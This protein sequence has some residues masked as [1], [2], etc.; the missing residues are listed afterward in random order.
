[1]TN[2]ALIAHSPERFYVASVPELN[3]V[4]GLALASKGFIFNPSYSRRDLAAFLK[5]GKPRMR[6]VCA[7]NAPLSRNAERQGTKADS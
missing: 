1:M 5:E 7:V 4:S 3:A 2:T 6:G